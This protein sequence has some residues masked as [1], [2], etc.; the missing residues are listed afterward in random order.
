MDGPEMEPDGPALMEDGLIEPM[1]SREK[2]REKEIQH[3]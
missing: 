3:A 1:V 2:R